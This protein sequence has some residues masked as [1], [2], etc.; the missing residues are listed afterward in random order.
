[1][2]KPYV[3]TYYAKENDQHL[4]ILAELVYK[5]LNPNTRFTWGVDVMPN[6]KSLIAIYLA[7]L[8][9]AGTIKGIGPAAKNT[10]KANLAEAMGDIAVDVNK[11]ADGNLEMLKS[12]GFPL[13]KEKSP[14]GELEKPDYVK[15]T[16]GT[17]AGELICDTPSFA[18]AVIYCFYTAPAP[19]PA[20][21]DEW[22][23]SISTNHKKKITG[24]TSGKKYAVRSAYQG[25]TDALNYSD[26]VY[27]Y[28]Q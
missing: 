10:A 14:I 19:E 7:K 2:E 1:M 20:N 27:I 22:K 16:N 23:L 9:E 4:Y 13:A 5:A 15:V 6:F 8:E 25:T 18:N 17:N 12:S 21:M 26:T 28:A 3:I 24:F 11:Q